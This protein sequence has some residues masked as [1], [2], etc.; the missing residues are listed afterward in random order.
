MEH[1]LCGVEL[2][3]WWEDT[4]SITSQKDNVAGVVC[5]QAGD[6]GVLDVLNGVGTSSVLRQS[7]I[8]IIDQ[9]SLRAEN[10]VLEN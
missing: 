1:G 8:I 4:T 3:N 2:G 9:T 7:G 10:N 6:L 5:R